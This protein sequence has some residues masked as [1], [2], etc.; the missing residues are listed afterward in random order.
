MERGPLK[1]AEMMNMYWVLAHRARDVVQDA[2]DSAKVIPADVATMVHRRSSYLYNQLYRFMSDRNNS[3]AEFRPTDGFD[4][5][6]FRTMCDSFGLV[7]KVVPMN[8]SK[9]V[10]AELAKE[11]SGQKTAE[12]RYANGDLDY[13][14]LFNRYTRDEEVDEVRTRRSTAGIVGSSAVEGNPYNARRDDLAHV[15]QVWKPVSN[16]DVVMPPSYDDMVQRDATLDPNYR[17]FDGEPLYWRVAVDHLRTLDDEKLAVLVQRTLVA[18]PAYASTSWALLLLELLAEREIPFSPGTLRAALKMSAER[19]DIYGLLEVLHACHTE[20]E[21]AQT[22]AFQE[23]LAALRKH[24]K[25]AMDTPPMLLHAGR[26]NTSETQNHPG[27]WENE[28][29]QLIFCC[30]MLF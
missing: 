27:K 4:R 30:K 13:V 22:P 29:K 28:T 7:H 11:K 9:Y 19:E 24:P 8:A 26:K 15:V 6:V 10:E 17:K 12:F 1:I 3:F 21:L 2:P 16:M 18:M 25:Y 14:S 5:R 20:Q 23:V